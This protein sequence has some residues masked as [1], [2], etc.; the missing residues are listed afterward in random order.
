MRYD[1]SKGNWSMEG[2]QYAYSCRFTQNSRFI[3]RED[4][5]ENPADPD[6]DYGYSYITLATEKKW[7]PGVRLTTH[8]S[9]Q[10]LAAPL[11]VL[12]KDLF[13]RDGLASYGD[14]QE[15]VLW[16]NGLNVWNLWLREDGQVE[17]HKLV[18]VHA[19]L[20]E[21]KIHELTVDV[22]EE[23]FEI[24]M[25]GQKMY[26]RDEHI[27]P[28]FYLGITGCEG[29]CRFYDMEVTELCEN[30]SLRQL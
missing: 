30:S 4:C 29:V 23:G 7:K 8:C 22:L 14:Y 28:E 3:Q 17:Y 11:V 25:D 10:G 26:V 1:F 15:V 2:L 12:V 9:F 6:M 21:E 13:E 27:Y 5:I 20:E 19:S 16:K 18:G 24:S